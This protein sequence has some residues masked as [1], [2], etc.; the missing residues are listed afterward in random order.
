MDLPQKLPAWLGLAG[1][2]SKEVL[3]TRE[4]WTNSV[5]TQGK[6]GYTLSKYKESLDILCLN[7]R[8][9]WLRSV[10]IKVKCEII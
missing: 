8:E 10:F 4:A 1:E 6:P 9:A 7:R 5:S 3:N 2:G